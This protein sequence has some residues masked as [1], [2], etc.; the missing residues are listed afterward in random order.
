[1]IA[2]NEIAGKE[3]SGLGSGLTI[4][5]IRN[6]IIEDRTTA[7]ALAGDYYERIRREDPE[8]GAFLTLCEERALAQAI[9]HILADG[10]SKPLAPLPRLVH[11]VA[12]RNLSHGRDFVGLQF[13]EPRDVFKNGVQIA[14]HANAFF[15]GQLKVGQIGHVSHV[16]VGNLHTFTL[17]P[18]PQTQ[19]ASP[20]SQNTY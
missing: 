8:I 16:F 6:A 20:K 11:A 15:L 4:E 9:L 18:S 12:I 14:Q 3:N 1:M 2:K 7:T 5:T 17:T 19:S 10:V 13:A